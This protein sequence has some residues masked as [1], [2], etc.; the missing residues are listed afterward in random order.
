MTNEEIY[1][2]IRKFR[3]IGCETIANSILNDHS[4]SSLDGLNRQT[5]DE[6]YFEL[7]SIFYDL[8]HEGSS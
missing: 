6:Y 3:E 7:D 2:Q 5:V 8:T 1:A 4:P